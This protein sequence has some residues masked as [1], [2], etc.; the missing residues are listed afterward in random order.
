[1]VFV[2]GRARGAARIG[3]ASCARRSAGPVGRGRRRCI[4]LVGWNLT[5]LPPSVHPDGGFPAGDAA[6]VRSIAALTRPASTRRCG[7]GALAA[8]VQ[9]ARGDGLSAGADRTAVRRDASSGAAALGSRPSS[10]IVGATVVLCDQLFREAIGAD[11]GGPAEDAAARGQDRPAG[12][13]A[14]SVRGGTRPVGL[15]LRRGGCPTADPRR[16]C[17][18]RR[19]RRRRSLSP[20]PGRWRAIRVV[21]WNALVA[22][23]VPA[24][25]RVT[26]RT[27]LTAVTP[28]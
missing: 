24:G 6:A 26:D 10:E 28:T 3:P 7:R 11:C 12:A 4:A 22:A 21:P 15:G 19:P 18:R 2:A 16:T 13:L 14:R 17:E 8:R 1:M 27:V 23:G 5:H 20:R 25:P 9:V